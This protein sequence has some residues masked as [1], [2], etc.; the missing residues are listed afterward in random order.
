MEANRRSLVEGER[1]FQR[2]DVGVACRLQSGDV[3]VQS[4]EFLIYKLDT[5]QLRPSLG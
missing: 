3:R 2:I 4:C 1:C 5:L